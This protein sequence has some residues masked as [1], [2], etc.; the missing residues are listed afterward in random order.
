[1][2]T[3]FPSAQF[4]GIDQ[5]ALF[6]HD[7][8]PANVTFQKQDVLLGLP[9]EDNTFDLVQMRLFSLAFT[10][11]QWAEALKEAYRVTKPGGF[12]Q[13]LEVQLEVKCTSVG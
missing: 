6:P 5:V 9:F 7:I 4:V 13:F 8:R 10:R 3:E 12:V 11:S 1:M 2:A